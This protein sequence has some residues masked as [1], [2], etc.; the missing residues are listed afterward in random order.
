MQRGIFLLSIIVFLSVLATI[1][2]D[3]AFAQQRGGILKIYHW[4]NPASMSIHE[5]GGYS[6]AVTGMA[7]FNNL[8]LYNQHVSQNSLRSIVPELAEE[9]SW[10]A[11]Q[12]VLSFHLR[13]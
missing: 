6:T 9:W 1:P 7:V 2:I 5:E 11:D 3:P 13:S 8:V 4:L 12:T 10:N